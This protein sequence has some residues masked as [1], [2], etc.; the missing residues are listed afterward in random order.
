MRKLSEIRGED[1][2]DILADLIEPASE[3]GTDKLF[4]ELVRKNDKTG[5]VRQAIKGHKKAVLT[6]MAILEGE[7]PKTYQPS[8][9]R[10]PTMLIELF[11]DPELI[12]LFTSG[13]TVTSSGSATENTEG[14]E[15]E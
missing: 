8:L 11:N 14:T 1:A 9:L 6:I 2:L 10:L 5:A 12:A 13:Q 3:F 7:D 15:Q 4:A